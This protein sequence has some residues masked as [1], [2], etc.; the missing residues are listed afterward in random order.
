[1][2]QTETLALP[3]YTDVAEVLQQAKAGISAAEAHG[4]LCGMLSAGMETGGHSWF[5]PILGDF[6]SIDSQ[7]AMVREARRF[8]ES[9][10]MITDEQMWDE[11]LGF[12]LLLPKDERS[13]PERLEALAN[14]CHGFMSGIGLT[15][16][17]IDE[18][19]SDDTKEA[20]EDI[21][22]IARIETD[23]LEEGETLAAFEELVEFVRMAALMIHTDFHRYDE[24]P[25]I[26]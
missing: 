18:N 8:F 23:E 17:K 25:Q 5:S 14:W 7:D 24:K 12:H 21:A 15:G 26:H 11:A 9:I 16:R 19:V 1:M 6:E 20:L 4:L 22:Q 10:V 3:E 13:F 2:G